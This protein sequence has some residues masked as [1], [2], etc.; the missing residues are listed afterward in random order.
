MQAEHYSA[1]LTG[2]A[3]IGLAVGSLFGGNMIRTGR[4]RALVLGNFAAIIGSLMSII[5]N[6]QVICLGRFIV[7]L[8][9]G[10]IMA[11]SPKVIEET[12]PS[13]LMCYGYGISTNI[14]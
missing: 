4:H 8:S 3:T 6:F 14:A 12:I 11:A 9:A 2:S 13:H 7:G 10:M 1:I 5:A